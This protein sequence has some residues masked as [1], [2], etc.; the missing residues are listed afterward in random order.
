MPGPSTPADAH[1]R[2]QSVRRAFD[3]L[4]LI[5][6]T[7]AGAALSELAA[8]SGLPVPT[9]HRLLRGLVD[10]G[11]VVQLSSRRY[12]LGPRM[13][14]LG[15]S[16]GRTLDAWA[17]PHLTR[18][19]ELTGETANLAMLEVGQVV[20]L[21]QTSSQ[22]HIVRMFT[23]VGSRVSPHCTGVGKAMLAELPAETAREIVTAAG[24]PARTR[25]TITDPDALLEELA[26]VR[27]AG[28][29]VDD[30]E[31]EL[32]VRCLAVVV[33]G[34]P[35]TAISVSGPASRLTRRALGRLVPVVRAAARDLGDAL[36]RPREPLREATDGSRA[37]ATGGEQP[38]NAR[39]P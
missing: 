31:Q 38:R 26:R 21:A 32:G 35:A 4:H 36:G 20:Y 30:E 5:A 16:A 11:H 22:R 27:A 10:S 6:L 3:L 9:I 17:H 18:L 24:M 14:G 7:D 13:L 8:A 29:A 33:R 1:G 34:L 23:E 12:A 2:V 25:H 19:S 28:H 15:Q 37:R 39:R